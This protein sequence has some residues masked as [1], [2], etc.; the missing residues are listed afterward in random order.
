M[1]TDPYT[2][3]V[4][5]VLATMLLTGAGFAIAAPQSRRRADIASTL[6]IPGV[7][8]AAAVGAYAVG[9]RAHFYHEAQ[10]IPVEIVQPTSST[11]MKSP[12]RV[13]RQRFSQF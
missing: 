6:A 8:I 4:G 12:S 2:L 13:A 10:V 5:T 1:T 11:F 9:I 3:I 7:V